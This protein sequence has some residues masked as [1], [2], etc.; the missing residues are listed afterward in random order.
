MGKTPK[1]YKKADG[2][3]S[4]RVKNILCQ[5]YFR[6]IPGRMR[7]LYIILSNLSP[8]AKKI[9]IYGKYLFFCAGAEIR[10]Y[11]TMTC[12]L[13]LVNCRRKQTQTMSQSDSIRAHSAAPRH[14]AKRSDWTA[15]KNQEKR[16]EIKVGFLVE[17]IRRF[18][19]KYIL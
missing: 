4:P 18:Y 5:K 3:V 17:K 7:I 19:S 12:F 10:Q 11:Q 16:N 1:Q 6:P 8:H 9:S 14:N 15:Q 13:T 2:D